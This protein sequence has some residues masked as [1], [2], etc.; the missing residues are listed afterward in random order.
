MSAEIS[1]CCIVKDSFYYC[2]Y[3]VAINAKEIYRFEFRPLKKFF[4]QSVGL[5]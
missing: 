2:R 5:A 1:T 4:L 3:L